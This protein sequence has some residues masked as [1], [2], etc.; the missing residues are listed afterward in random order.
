MVYEAK[1]PQSYNKA[2]LDQGNTLRLVGSK[3]NQDSMTFFLSTLPFL[4]IR[5]K[6]FYS[7]PSSSNSYMRS[8]EMRTSIQYMVH[9]VADFFYT[10]TETLPFLTMAAAVD[11]S[12]FK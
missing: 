3:G 2:M 8:T 6:R 10:I 9:K 12:G 4:V 7:R 5:G 1:F 11:I